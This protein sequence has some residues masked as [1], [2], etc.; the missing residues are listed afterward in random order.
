MRAELGGH[1]EYHQRRELREQIRSGRLKIKESA[2]IAMPI[3]QYT[4]YHLAVT[5]ISEREQE[6]R[7]AGRTSTPI[8]FVVVS[9]GWLVNEFV[10]G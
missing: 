5:I 4:E 8:F 9:M 2:N 6:Q 7:I 10:V 3:K 1:A